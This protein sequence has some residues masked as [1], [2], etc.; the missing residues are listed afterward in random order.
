MT[1]FQLRTI[2]DAEREQGKRNNFLLIRLV[3]AIAV[4]YGHAFAISPAD[5]YADAVVRYIGGVWSGGVALHSFFIISGFLVAA[6]YLHRNSLYDY[7]S[8]RV[9]RIMPG[10][11]VCMLLMTLA[12][13]PLNTTLKLSRYFRDATVLDYFWHNVLLLDVRYFLPGVFAHL[14]APGVN[15]PIGSLFV[16]GRLYL[17]LAAVGLCGLLRRK[18]LFTALSV[19]A[20]AVGLF[21]PEQFALLA[22]GSNNLFCCLLFLIGTLIYLHR[23]RIPLNGGLM[24]FFLFVAVLFHDTPRFFVAFTAMLIYGVLYLAYVPRVKWLEGMG[25]YSY[26]VYIYGWPAQQI[27]KSLF[28]A[29]TPL[30]NF[31]IA[32]PA[33]LALAVLSWHFIEKPALSL[34]GVSPARLW[35][36]LRRRRNSQLTGIAGT[37]AAGKI[38]VMPAAEE[39]MSERKAA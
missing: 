13:G 39:P 7:L 6:S 28:P 30:G 25:D 3:A 16:E 2:G 1:T 15:G 5:G 18:Q 24:L 27:A 33:A 29:T 14:P 9:L 32:F 31:A 20:A 11:L 8:A 23:D 36:A 19:A 4:V 37:G 12:V 26:G 22:T 17:V 10:L 35:A 38:L 34:K 21:Y